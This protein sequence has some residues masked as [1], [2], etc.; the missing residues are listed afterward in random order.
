VSFCVTDRCFSAFLQSG[1][2]HVEKGH[3]GKGVIMTLGA[4]GR[5]SANW[6]R[7]EFVH[8]GLGA[9]AATGL[10][11]CGSD[12]A[13]PN[14][15]ETSDP[16]LMARPGTP[17][18][19]APLGRSELGLADPRDGFLYVPRSYSSSNPAPL[20]VGLHG[21]GGS[22]DTW[23]G[24]ET[25]AEE[26][27]FVLLA[28]ESRSGTWDVADVGYFGPD[29]E[30]IDTALAHTFERCRIDP[31]RIALAGFSDG[32]SYALSLGVSN[33]DLFTHL[34][35]FSAGFYALTAPVVGKPRVYQSHGTADGVLPFSYGLD[36]SE[37]LREQGYDV[38]FEQFDGGHVVP[39]DISQNA[40]D[41]FLALS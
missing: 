22:A 9:I 40:L 12:P 38:T 8:A 3:G 20:F 10:V 18:S 4:A 24:F 15:P 19:G 23:S 33:G 16:R 21:S 29:V 34:I 37:L 11:G 14:T 5:R 17:T 35:A 1:G 36:I 41:W 27:G 32:A 39:Y 26:R 30:F 7:R 6:S 28:P 2:S 13:S 25:Y 31:A